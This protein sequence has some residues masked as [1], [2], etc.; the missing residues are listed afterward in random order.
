[1][2]KQFGCELQRP[3]VKTG[4]YPRDEVVKGDPQS[5]SE[6][7]EQEDQMTG[8]QRVTR[9]VVC[10]GQNTKNVVKFLG[11]E[12]CPWEKLSTRRKVKR[13]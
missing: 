2:I 11:R 4:S 8:V 1:M 5:I 9:H 13:N 6:A 10:M 12:F 7:K 3:K